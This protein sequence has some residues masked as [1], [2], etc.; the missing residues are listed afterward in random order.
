MNRS[1]NMGETAK[2]ETYSCRPGLKLAALHSHLIYLCDMP[3][4]VGPED[5]RCTFN[6]ISELPRIVISGPSLAGNVLRQKELLKS[7]PSRSQGSL[8]DKPIKMQLCRF[9]F[10]TFLLKQRASPRRSKLEP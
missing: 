6:V 10:Q 5:R 2:T 3:V 9:P 4:D 7:F 8:D 1:Q